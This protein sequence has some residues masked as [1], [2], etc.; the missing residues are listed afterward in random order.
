LPGRRTEPAKRRQQLLRS[1]PATGATTRNH[2][3]TIEKWACNR[4]ATARA[5]MLCNRATTRNENHC[6]APPK[7]ALAQQLYFGAETDV[8]SGPRNNAI[9]PWQQRETARNKSA[10]VAL[11]HPSRNK[12][13]SPLE[14][15]KSRCAPRARGLSLRA[16]RSRLGCAAPSATLRRPLR[17]RRAAPLSTGTYSTTSPTGRGTAPSPD[18]S[19]RGLRGEQQRR[20]QLNRSSHARSF[21]NLDCGLDTGR[22]SPEQISG[23]PSRQLVL[24]A[25]IVSRFTR[26]VVC[27]LRL[28]QL[29][30]I[31]APICVFGASLPP[32]IRAVGTHA[33]CPQSQ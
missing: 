33:A 14:S 4:P 7:M 24:V 1:E 12:R 3:A 25:S 19:D 32:D 29:S 16:C 9:M 21:E 27:L 23:G 15:R 18:K 11:L 5:T 17:Q 22:P 30:V 2:A 20:K 31:A 8:N 6:C 26:R 10:P 28:Q 13:N